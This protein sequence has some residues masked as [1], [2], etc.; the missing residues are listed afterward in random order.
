MLVPNITK[1]YNGVRY[2]D[3]LTIVNKPHTKS[4]TSKIPKEISKKFP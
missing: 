1:R 4:Y 3:S 2:P